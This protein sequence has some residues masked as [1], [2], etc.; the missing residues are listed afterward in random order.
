MSAG[1]FPSRREPE[2]QAPAPSGGDRLY[3]LTALIRALTIAGRISGRPDQFAA[4]LVALRASKFGGN[5]DDLLAAHSRRRARLA[6]GSATARQRP[7]PS[8]SSAAPATPD[9][10][11]A[12]NAGTGRSGPSR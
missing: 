2:G 10:V 3:A 12:P 1:A 11:A 5:L 4:I 8:M 7:R 9:H 6:A